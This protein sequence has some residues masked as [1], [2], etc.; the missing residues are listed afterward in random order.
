[1][2]ASDEASA[3]SG[4][5]GSDRGDDLLP[6]LQCGEPVLRRPAGRVDPADLRAGRFRRLIEQ[7]RATMYAAPG[8]GLAAPQVGVPLQLAVLEDS[9]DRW[10]ELDPAALAARERTPLPFTVLVNPAVTAVGDDTAG[11]F[12]GCLSVSGLTGLVVR[13]RRVRVHALDEHGEPVD[14]EF[15]GW[16]ARIVQHETDHLLGV[17]YLDR[18]ETRSLCT[19]ENYARLWAGRQAEAAAALGFSAAAP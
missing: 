19:A 3:A 9:P 11:F 4:P 10:G 17:L 13:R 5:G 12:E 15:T 2:S 8:V 7:L 6:I 18:V 16:P 14:Q 1:M